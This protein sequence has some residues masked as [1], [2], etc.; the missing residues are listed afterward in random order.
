[1]RDL[2]SRR[3]VPVPQLEQLVPFLF[4]NHHGPQMYAPDNL[5]LP[6]DPDPQWVK[7]VMNTVHE[8]NQATLEY[9]TGKF[10]IKL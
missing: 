6:F 4:L 8:I 9:Q 2:Q 7:P 1:M 5:G 10:D 3:P